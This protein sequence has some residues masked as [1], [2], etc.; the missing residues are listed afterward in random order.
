MQYDAFDFLPSGVVVIDAETGRLIYANRALL[1]L[2]QVEHLDEEATWFPFVAE[3]VID[4]IRQSVWE[5]LAYNGGFRIEVNISPKEDLSLW[6]VAE[7]NID[8]DTPTII[9]SISE[10]TEIKQLQQELSLKSKHLEMINETVPGGILIMEHDPF[11]TVTYANNGFYEMLGYTKEEF[12]QKLK[13][14]CVDLIHPDDLSPTLESLERQTEIGNKFELQFRVRKKDDGIIWISCSGITVFSQERYDRLNCIILDIDKNIKLLDKLNKEQELSRTIFDLSDDIIFDYDI[15]NST[16]SLSANVS[17]K[18]KAP[19]FLTDCP[20]SIIDAGIIHEDDVELFLQIVEAMRL[21]ISNFKGEIRVKLG[22]DQISWFSID[23]KL[24]FDNELFP[25]KSLG[26]ITDVTAQRGLIED[27]QIKAKTD[28]L[29]KVYN[30]EA[31]NEL[32]K[33]SLIQNFNVKAA[34]FVIDI[35]NFKGVNDNLGHQFGDSVLKIIADNIKNEFRENDIVGRIGGDEFVVFIKRIPSIDVVT[36]KAIA[37][38]NAFR[39]T[40][41][42][43]KND[44]KISGSIGISIYPQDGTSFEELFKHADL[45]LYESKKRGKDCYSFYDESLSNKNSS[46]TNLMLYDERQIANYYKDD[47]IYNIFEMLYETQDLYT[48]I[49]MVLEIVGKQYGVDRCYIFEKS[50]NGL[51]YSN[52]FE[53][54]NQGTQPLIDKLQNLPESLF[55][56]LFSLYSTEGIYFSNRTEDFQNIELYSRFPK[57]NLQSFLHCALLNNGKVTG[58][59]GYHDCKNQRI[60]SIEEI[61]TLSYIAKI[62]SI[63]LVK[64]NMFQELI[65]SFKNMKTMLDN[66]KSY[67]YVIDENT[68]ETLYV[69]KEL[70][71]LFREDFLGNKCHLIAFSRNEPCK[72]CPKN[73]LTGGLLSHT[74]EAYNPYLKIRSLTTASRIIWTGGIPA[75]LISCIDITA[76]KTK[77]EDKAGEEAKN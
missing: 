15:I 31:T 49:N 58:F 6:I 18:Y 12:T 62:L 64:K 2:L 1:N 51:F 68:H 67:I 39:R 29:T 43:E 25:V 65:A 34:L 44:Y 32:I 61:S 57:E 52:T 42:G 14:R 69:N 8:R 74:T 53:W 73:K 40:Y 3:G 45:A 26:K 50:E 16:V 5:Q 24:I 35:D 19:S 70:A 63:F 66:M 60:W 47:L 4:D 20:K 59:I 77:D 13:N 22:P 28:P 9:V 75:I 27:L 38:T 33:K 36:Q 30:K 7:G 54:C 37:L 23:Y 48:T 76:Y 10:I 21:G 72:N 17:A 11:L 71:K 41:C 46:D 56:G 55:Q